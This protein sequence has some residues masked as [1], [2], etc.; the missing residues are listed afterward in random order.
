MASV[1]KTFSAGGF[2]GILDW[3]GKDKGT[4]TWAN[5]DT[6]RGHVTTGG[7]PLNASAHPYHAVDQVTNYVIGDTVYYPYES[8]LCF[9]F[10]G[11]YVRANHIGW[12]HR[13]GV[14]ENMTQVRLEAS[15]DGW[16]W[17]DL[18][19]LSFGDNAGTW[20]DA[21]ITNPGWYRFYRFLPVELS[22]STADYAIVVD[23]VEFYGDYDDSRAA[24]D[25]GSLANIPLYSD[26]HENGGGILAW[27]ANGKDW[28][29]TWSNPSSGSGVVTCTQSS[30]LGGM[31]ADRA[32]TAD[33]EIG[34][35]RSHT[36]NVAGSWWKVDFGADNPVVVSDA[37]IRAHNF[38]SNLPRNF[39]L[40]G[41]TNDSDW[42]DLA[43]VT[44][45][46]PAQRD[47]YLMADINSEVEYRYLRI[48]NTGVDSS[49]GNYLILGGFEVW[50]TYGSGPEVTTP[51]GQYW[52]PDGIFR[53]QVELGLATQT[54]SDVW[55]T[56]TW[57][58]ATWAATSPVYVDV[59]E[60]VLGF[61]CKYGRTRFD[62]RMKTGNARITFDN[63]E[64]WFNPDAG[65]DFNESL[66]LRPGRWIRLSAVRDT[67]NAQWD[68][69]EGYV[70]S[71]EERYTNGGSDSITVVDAFDF[72]GLMAQHDEPAQ[73]AAGSGEL[74]GARVHRVLDEFGPVD[75]GWPWR[76][77][78]GG[79]HTMQSTTL[80]QNLLEE[81]QRA[82][83]ADN[84]AFFFR[85]R[86]ATFRPFDW[87]TNQE[88][89]R[90]QEVQLY[91]GRG[92]TGDPEI[93]DAETE[94]TAQ[95]IRND[96]Q[97]SRDGGSAQRSQ[98]T[99]SQGIYGRHSWHRLDLQND[100]DAD[101]SD[102]ADAILAAY[103]YDYQRLKAVT[104]VPTTG[105]T[106]P[107]LLA[108]TAML[109]MRLG[110]LVSVDV[111]LGPRGWSY[112]TEA[113]VMGIQFDVAPAF[114]SMTLR[115]D[116]SVRG[117][118]EESS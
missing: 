100:T 87:L 29:S 113:H 116:Q 32:L 74:S 26:S 27:L 65:E 93:I 8:Y 43:T 6:V 72:A 37:A 53:F 24:V 44:G 69:W 101:V 12:L 40:Q 95:V 52:P 103:A 110:D 56:G 46:G 68:L 83:D 36:D 4:T 99:T 11:E 41:S 107:D 1:S 15:S 66:A 91:P 2:N 21:A 80:A 16:A 28:V 33:A 97:M 62:E 117:N 75:G 18:G 114:W 55:D 45:A 104:I 48:L 86:Y 17:T 90:S 111:D 3:L 115:L 60:H 59:T 79:L 118:P 63:A 14:S 34:T 54:G 94:W 85:N 84:G 10:G 19:L 78:A 31:T 23:D 51:G 109:D 39:K 98:D 64:G 57:G 5:P 96:V 88:Y 67:D 7:Y 30:T 92:S 73:S 76:D 106:T 61:T 25:A 58:T 38:G 9:D 13:T 50:G 20:E 71:I 47:W 105:T 89:E 112:T 82:A 108:V 77:V 42:D 102:I 22:N 70:Y 81:A 49:G 35:G